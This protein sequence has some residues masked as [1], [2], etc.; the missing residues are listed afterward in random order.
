MF[1]P[2][3]GEAFG[4]HLVVSSIDRKFST[5][6]LSNGDCCSTGNVI[7]GEETEDEE[8][9]GDCYTVIMMQLKPGL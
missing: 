7:G 5:I 8:G 3:F 2:N 1:A 4:F 9:I 6:P